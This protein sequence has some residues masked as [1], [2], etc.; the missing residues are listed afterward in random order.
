MN[1]CVYIYI[2]SFAD[3]SYMNTLK[4]IKLSGGIVE[5]AVLCVCAY[6]YILYLLDA[7]HFMYCA[8]KGCLRVRARVWVCVIL[9]PACTHML[10]TCACISVDTQGVCVC[11]VL[12]LCVYIYTSNWSLPGGGV[13][14]QGSVMR[15]AVG[16]QTQSGFGN[17]LG[18]HV[19]FCHTPHHTPSHVS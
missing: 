7:T 12:Y 8:C 15:N 2:Y 19:R 1:L 10:C 11:L 6:I 4:S 18:L 16:L 14:K 9:L 3:L 13:R 17:W 5:P